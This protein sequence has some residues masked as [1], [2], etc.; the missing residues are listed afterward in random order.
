[1]EDLASVKIRSA[2]ANDIEAT[3]L[4]TR[5]KNAL[6][7]NNIVS[8]AKLHALSTEEISVLS[9]LGD[10][11]IKEFQW[12]RPHRC[13]DVIP[14]LEAFAGLVAALVGVLDSAFVNAGVQQGDILAIFAI[15][16]LAPDENQQTDCAIWKILIGDVF[17]AFRT[18]WLSVVLHFSNPFRWLMSLM[19]AQSMVSSSGL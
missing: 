11:S 3:T 7:K 17:S 2:K 8:L 13:S 19:Y 9:G 14:C 6:A 16:S 12:I 1:M 15:D 10:K 4:S 18:K 5:S